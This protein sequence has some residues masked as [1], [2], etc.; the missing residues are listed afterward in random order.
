MNELS[1]FLYL[2]DVIPSLGTAAQITFFFLA[3][4]AAIAVFI[5]TMC[6]LDTKL[7]K[8]DPSRKDKYISLHFPGWCLAAFFIFFFCWL[9]SFLVPSKETIYMIAASEAGEMIV[10]TPEAKEMLGDLKQIIKN[11]A[12]K[13]IP[14]KQ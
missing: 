10:N 4:V 14:V 5:F 12:I 1:W 6:H 2:A 7:Y 8:N 3:F 11:Y 9:S 13:S